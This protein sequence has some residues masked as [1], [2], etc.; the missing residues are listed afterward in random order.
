MD[1]QNSWE[2]IHY[3]I[4][5]GSNVYAFE[6]NSIFASYFI[7]NSRHIKNLNMF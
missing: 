1:F 6:P 4:N 5:N 7:T 3:L 2:K